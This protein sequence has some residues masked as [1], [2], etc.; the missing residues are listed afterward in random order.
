LSCRRRAPL[1][2]HVGPNCW[3]WSC[4]VKSG[5]HKA[6]ASV[7]FSFPDNGHILELLSRA[8]TLY[9]TLSVSFVDWEVL[10]DISPSCDHTRVSCF[11][12]IIHCALS[13]AVAVPFYVQQK[14][15][16]LLNMFNV[17]ANWSW[18]G[19]SICSRV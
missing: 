11:D 12:N 14:S 2:R 7:R 17:T 10:R 1:R 5:E 3:E 19:L 9:R 13:I 8:V 6:F 18:M 15:I 4:S 16:T